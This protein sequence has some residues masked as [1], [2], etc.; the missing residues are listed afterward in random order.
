MKVKVN[1]KHTSL[2]FEWD[3]K[4]YYPNGQRHFEAGFAPD[5]EALRKSLNHSFPNAEI[6]LLGL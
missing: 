4:G 1:V 6:E 5:I 3:Y 2:G